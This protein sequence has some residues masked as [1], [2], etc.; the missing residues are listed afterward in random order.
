M[1][2]FPSFLINTLVRKYSNCAQMC[3]IKL[4]QPQCKV[5]NRASTGGFICVIGTI[6]T[7]ISAPRI[8]MPLLVPN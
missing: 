7:A 4:L 6:A 2:W 8:A 1:N 3:D 5:C